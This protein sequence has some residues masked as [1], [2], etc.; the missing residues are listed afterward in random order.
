M[1]NGQRS[2]ELDPRVS[3]M[4]TTMMMD[5]TMY[6]T[7]GSSSYGA[8]AAGF[9]RRVVAAASQNNAAAEAS[10]DCRPHAAGPSTAGDRFSFGYTLTVNAV[11]NLQGLSEH[12]SSS[13][14]DVASRAMAP[15]SPGVPVMSG[16]SHGHHHHH[17]HHPA[18][19][20]TSL[21]D[22][23]S[24]S[25]SA[26]RLAV[27]RALATHGSDITRTAANEG[28]IHGSVVFAPTH[29]SAGF[30][31][32]GGGGRAAAEWR[33][34][35]GS[36]LSTSVFAL[37]L[38]S[39][40]AR[41]GLEQGAMSASTTAAPSRASQRRLGVGGGGLWGTSSPGRAMIDG[42][43]GGSVGVVTEAD[44][45][46]SFRSVRAAYGGGGG[47]GGRAATSLGLAPPPPADAAKLFSS[48]GAAGHGATLR[49][50]AFASSLRTAPALQPSPVFPP[51]LQDAFGGGSGG[52]TAPV[53]VP[54]PRLS[55]A[56]AAC[57]TVVDSHRGFSF[58]SSIAASPGFRC[59][60][61]TRPGPTTATAACLRSGLDAADAGTDGP[62]GRSA[63]GRQQEGCA[64]A[65]TGAP[66]AAGLRQGLAPAGQGQP[67]APS[68]GASSPADRRAVRR[69]PS[70]TRRLWGRGG[71]RSPAG[72]FKQTAHPEGFMA[73]AS[74]RGGGGGDEDGGS[75]ASGHVPYTATA[76]LHDTATD[77]VSGGS[78]GSAAPTSGLPCLAATTTCGQRLS[79]VYDSGRLSSIASGGDR[80]IYATLK[81]C[82]LVAAAAVQAA[83]TAGPLQ[84]ATVSLERPG[85]GGGTS[86]GNSGSGDGISGS[87]G[88]CHSADLASAAPSL[89]I[90]RA[91][92]ATGVVQAAAA[93][94]PNDA[95]TRMFVRKS[96]LL[97]SNLE[98]AKR[99]A[100]GCAGMRR[101]NSTPDLLRKLS[102]ARENPNL[103]SGAP[104]EATAFIAIE[105]APTA[106]ATS[107]EVT[108]GPAAT[109]AAECPLPLGEQGTVTVE[110]AAS[111]DGRGQSPAANDEQ[112]AQP[113]E[114]GPTPVPS[115]SSY[116]SSS[117]AAAAAATAAAAAAAADV[118]A[119]TAA[120]V[121][122]GVQQASGGPDALRVQEL[123]ECVFVQ[124]PQPQP[125]QQH[126]RRV[127]EGQGQQQQVQQ[128]QQ[129]QQQ[130]RQ[131]AGEGEAYHEVCAVLAVDPVTG[132][133]VVVLTQHDVTA[134]V[135]AERHLALVMETE[136]RLLE[137]LFPRHIL[138]YLAEEWTAGGAV[139]RRQE[140]VE[141]GAEAAQHPG[142]DAGVGRQRQRQGQ[143]W[144]A[145]ASAPPQ[146]L[147]PSWRP[148]VRDCNALATWHPQ[149]TLLFADIKG[150]TPICKEVQP[151]QVM[152][153]LNDLFSRFDANLDRFGVYKVETIG[154]CYFVAG[155]LI[156]EDQDGM[157][158]VRGQAGGS[159]SGSGRGRV[160]ASEDVQHAAAV[161]RFA[162]AMLEAARQVPSPTT[163]EPVA[164]RIGIHSG[165][166]VS[167]V[168]GTRMPRFCLFGDTVNT[169]SR[170]EST[171]APGAIHASEATFEL[172]GSEEGW[173]ATG[174]VEVKGKGHMR[175]FLWRP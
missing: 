45:N 79:M 125:P 27:A 118:S 46:G 145:D 120:G 172:L 70:Y 136:H 162:K 81:S 37:M 69:Q 143:A 134:K 111:V 16:D 157:A 30:C 4:S 53:P 108:G 161:F 102:L 9:R 117:A 15:L 47:G 68:P 150:F 11:N 89:P 10:P 59:W 127:Q 84:W 83:A 95:D 147:P 82:G 29:G 156:H 174:G 107:P 96:S 153:M 51:M 1:L 90:D 77:C 40:G 67:P 126:P 164:L 138:A 171:G 94:G 14:A 165:P 151:S 155:G 119:G 110:V 26:R 73:E 7:G 173:S 129:M 36:S 71:L 135:L 5:D 115:A 152:T 31:S 92:G 132:E 149:V 175:T 3:L 17:H 13:A 44:D 32:G 63:D 55:P 56:A 28:L 49:S 137:Q 33:A 98:P 139:S 76:S 24:R 116:F 91:P 146:L 121:G 58:E 42:G 159:C 25:A 85:R 2:I 65:T 50:L 20:R 128:Q 163:G 167:G 72:S 131:Q 12:L 141:K 97:G 140:E 80:S 21:P 88:G 66:A 75:T 34:S 100:G 64:A 154:D 169:A 8:G 123:Q 106:A 133:D 170:M 101:H 93:G 38:G 43:G 99:L 114:A 168:V 103:Q 86:D 78:G 109:P 60:A 105:L 62:M 35:G 148:A 52:R 39:G 130:Q 41:G 124:Q 87:G 112:E 144:Q 6:G 61:A 54:V 113:A 122:L 104:Q 142:H 74:G 57:S 22:F 158:A 18:R 48:G 166:V 19:S 160:R 23:T